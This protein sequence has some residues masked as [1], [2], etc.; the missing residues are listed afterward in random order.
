MRILQ[1]PLRVVL[2]RRGTFETSLHVT[3][4]AKARDALARWEAAVDMRPEQARLLHGTVLD[5]AGV[6]I[7]RIQTERNT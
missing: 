3:S 5:R 2:D 4:I 7:T 1:R 6:P